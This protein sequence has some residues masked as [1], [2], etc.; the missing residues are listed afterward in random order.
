MIRRSTL[1]AV[2]IVL[3]LLAALLIG[4]G[5]AWW[6]LSQGPVEL[7]FLR[8]TVQTELSAARSGRPVGL[9]RVELAWVGNALEL[10]AVGVTVEDGR[11]GVLS[12]AE[13]ARIEL[14]VLP[15][16]IGRI[17][18]R[19]ADF[20]GGELSVTRR[21][22]GAVHLAF[23]PLG[24]APDIIIP[25][26]PLNETLQARVGRVL[27]G[28]AEGF[29]PVGAGG[30]LRSLSITGAKL[31]I[32]DQ[33]GGG[34]WTADSANF[35]LA[36]QGDALALV[37]DARL[38]GAEGL[39]P[40][41]LR[42]TTDTQFQA[43]IVDFSA[44]N[45]RPR[46]L[47]SQAALGPFAGLDAPLTATVSIGLDRQRGVTRL[48]GD[49]TLGRGV[50]DMAGGR[51]QL[52]GGSIRGRY[53]LESD[54]V[55][56]DQLQLAGD[57]TR[58]RGEVRVRDASAIF[59][60]R[61]DQPAAFDISFPAMVLDVPGT[62]SQPMSLSEVQIVGAIT[63]ADRAIRF[64]RIHAQTG[65]GAFD[66]TG[67]YYWAEAGADRA[68]HPGIELTGALTGS[69]E[70]PA[71]FALWP[72]GL[73][74]GARSYLAESLTAGRVSDATIQ[75]DIRPSDIAAGQL[76]NEAVDVRFNVS[77]AQM[78]FV[79]TMY[80]V[81]HAR[82]SGVL[83]GNRFDMDV[84]EA[85]LNNIV[86]TN[87][88]VEAPRFKPKGAMLTISA[89]AEG[90]VRNILEF[91]NQEPIGLGERLPIETA[92]ATGRGVVDIRIQRP[93]LSDVPFE[94]W[95]FT[96]NGDITNFAGNM[97]TRRV[98]LSQGRL[99]V[100]GDQRAISV[101]GPVRAGGSAVNVSW[102]EYLNR[103]ESSSS[104]YEIS[105]D[106]NAEDLV[107]LGYTVAEYAEG[108]IGV[109]IAGQGR[110]FDVD[111]A[112]VEVDLRNAA[113]TAPWSFWT[114]RP[115][116][117]A[118][119]RFDLARE[120]DGS[121][122]VNNIDG[123]G[124]G[125]VAQGRVR[126]SR[127]NHLMEVNLTRLAVEGRSDAR[128]SAIRAQDGGMDVRVTGALFDGAPF[129]D[130]DDGSPRTQTAG[131]QQ[132]RTTAQ[133]AQDPP[134]RAHVQVARLKLRGGATMSDA[135]V[136]LTTQRG[137]LTVLTAEG[138]APS[139][140]AFSLGLGP[141][142]G[143]PQGRLR[144]RSDDG[145]FAVRALT[146]SENV[147]GGTAIVDGE[148]RAGPPSTSRFNVSLSDFQVVQMPAMARLLSSAGSLTGLVE[149]LNGD[150]IGF[151][152]LDADVVYAN[153]RFT[154]REARLAGP[155]L[156]LTGSGSYDVE[157]DNLDVDGV[158][159]PSYGI[160]SMLGNLPVLGQLFVSREGEG[161]VGMT[162]SIN[163]PVAEPRVGVN[164]LSALTP[165]IFRRI[166][167]PIQRPAAPRV[168]A[169][170]TPPADHPVGEGDASAP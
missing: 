74:E 24:S 151:N 117:A 118:S 153:D 73:A 90:D 20:R 113:V 166:F 78:R 141:R 146:G 82:G 144:L 68:V 76:R 63:P 79:D 13:E 168:Q 98:A 137:A 92:T 110:G 12:R 160:N 142:P 1:I 15:L 103:P 87:G 55:I 44:E 157:R 65:Q 30:R 81:T 139:G 32:T 61:G 159:V 51:F 46:A 119:A 80:P 89:H 154:F 18:V 128:L 83:R 38:E 130:G 134:L 111:N 148:W 95:R 161:V 77:D 2:E 149:M 3:G 104:E 7:G 107:R 71:V 125:M 94:D 35:E 42:I 31:S 26:P 164:P 75:L 91:L 43:A 21:I 85:R 116:Q 97:T 99:A 50:A 158:V 19:K 39:A 132:V 40:A 115:G 123:R 135:R 129:M 106:F 121:L 72:M 136:D 169:P 96:V 59:A 167:E 36:R 25:P 163:G 124:A 60:A 152:D 84:T 156:G 112:N 162:Y 56:L 126:V 88:R 108:R 131:P 8:E 5:V 145:G 165:G 101:T 37:A 45:V 62:F 69:I 120:P 22:D 70:A 109:T 52:D 27:D 28:L 48:E 170:A 93:M 6:R 29:R 34:V 49:A 140:R 138:R 67:R 16:L 114:K 66:A 127:D 155:S 53:D 23:G 58:I 41:R 100:R 105:G 64:T 54:E 143:D 47:L 14:G 133:R 11:G 147:V 122:A 4:L 33:A 10:R 17:S 86:L 150:G 102:N 9:D 57:R